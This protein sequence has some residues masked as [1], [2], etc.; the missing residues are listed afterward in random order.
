MRFRRAKP[1]PLYPVHLRSLGMLGS[2]RDPLTWFRCPAC[3]YRTVESST[4]EMTEVCE[5][6]W[7]PWHEPVTLEVADAA[8][9]HHETAK[10]L[11]HK[12]DLIRR[13]YD[14]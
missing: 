4:E 10:A 12:P 11:D 5:G 9:A 7:G 2:P 6:R 3:G 13:A 1:E 14:A 8:S